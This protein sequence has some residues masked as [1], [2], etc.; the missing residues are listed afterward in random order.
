MG[1]GGA[2]RIGW[3]THILE[4]NS[5]ALPPPLRSPLAGYMGADTKGSAWANDRW[6]Q[7]LKFNFR[8]NPV[9]RSLRQGK[10]DHARRELPAQFNYA[11]TP[12]RSL[13]TTAAGSI[14]QTPSL[15]N[16]AA[17]PIS[18]FGITP[19]IQFTA[20][21][22]TTILCRPHHPHAG[23]AASTGGAA[24]Q[25]AQGAQDAQDAGCRV[26]SFR[27]SPLSIFPPPAPRFTPRNPPAPRAG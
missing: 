10:R 5:R 25:Y 11:A 12:H 2:G 7:S 6:E 24:G 19:G 1:V 18:P 13:A 3:K 8:G 27:M 17:P 26:G 20:W 9:P 4:L 16:R 14:A 21:S 22:I 23:S 15:R